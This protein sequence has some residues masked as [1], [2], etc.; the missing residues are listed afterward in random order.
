MNTEGSSPP[1]RSVVETIPPIQERFFYHSF[2]RRGATNGPEIDKG[3]EILAAIRDFGL[4]LTPE[5]IE[6]SQPSSGGAPSRIFPVLQ[7]R[8]SF[9]ELSPSELPQ[10]AEKFG[11]FALEF[12]IDTLRRLGAVPVLYVPQP[13]NESGASALGTALL[14]IVLDA[15]VAVTRLAYLYKMLNGSMPVLKE[16][17]FDVGFARNPDD[18]GAFTINRDEAKNI[19][20][21]VGY[22]V[23]PWDAL[24]EGFQTLK[25]L[26]YFTDNAKRD[27]AL[28]YY[29]QREWRIVGNFSI[30]GTQ[31]MR[32]PTPSE[33][34]R[35]LEIDKD[36]FARV[37]QTD[38]GPVDTL[39]QLLVYPGLNDKRIIE[40]VRRIIVPA[41]A[42]DRVADIL[43][44]LNNPPQV[45]AMDQPQTS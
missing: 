33:K 16:F 27:K 37:T 6:W 32:E 4:L 5:S 19:L 10:H 7:R 21:A 9:T 2:P 23:T 34:A 29:R 35:L 3:C 30:N 42:V 18:R 1:A 45:V 11:Q 8:A 14:A 15:Q 41:E 25:S 24:A 39:S 40:M 12:E 43:D 31:A 36:F 44:E 22:A 38:L 28:D 13:M 20:S 26:F 17:S